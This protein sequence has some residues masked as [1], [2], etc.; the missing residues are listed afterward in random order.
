MSGKRRTP[1]TQ[2]GQAPPLGDER[3]D[4]VPTEVEDTPLPADE[5]VTEV[6]EQPPI[7]E[8]PQDLQATIHDGQGRGHTGDTLPPDALET[9]QGDEAG[10]PTAA[11]VPYDATATVQDAP[12]FADDQIQVLTTPASEDPELAADGGE[13]RI[14]PGPA[15][16]AGATDTLGDY[17]QTVDDGDDLEES[18]DLPEDPVDAAVLTSLEKAASTGESPVAAI[19]APTAEPRPGI[20]FQDESTGGPTDTATHSSISTDPFGPQQP[21]SEAPTAEAATVETPT[22][23]D[24]VTVGQ[25]KYQVPEAIQTLNEEGLTRLAEVASAET[26]LMYKELERLTSV[27]ELETLN[28]GLDYYTQLVEFVGVDQT[29]KLS[30]LIHPTF[31]RDRANAGDKWIETNIEQLIEV[32]DK[33]IP[34]KYTRSKWLATIFYDRVEKEHSAY[35]TKNMRRPQ[36]E[37]P[38]VDT[39]AQTVTTPTT[40][41]PSPA[42]EGNTKY[43]K[44]KATKPKRRRR[45]LSLGCGVLGGLLICGGALTLAYASITSWFGGEP[46]QTGEDYERVEFVPADDDTTQTIEIGKVVA[47]GSEVDVRSVYPEEATTEEPTP[48][49]EEPRPSFEDNVSELEHVL[50]SGTN[51]QISDPSNSRR[52]WIMYKDGKLTVTRSGDTNAPK[53]SNLVEAI[54]GESNL[55]NTTDSGETTLHYN[56]LIPDG[57]AV[58][59]AL[60]EGTEIADIV[61]LILNAIPEGAVAEETGDDDDATDESVT[62]LRYGEGDADA[63]ADV[64]RELEEATPAETGIFNGYKPGFDF[65]RRS[66]QEYKDGIGAYARDTFFV[67]KRKAINYLETDESSVFFR[68]GAENTTMSA[69][70]YCTGPD[71]NP[72]KEKIIFS[73]TDTES[74]H[75]FDYHIFQDGRTR[76]IITDQEGNRTDKRDAETTKQHYA[77]IFQYFVN[78]T[79]VLD[80]VPVPDAVIE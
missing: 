76:E 62:T 7:R 47:G 78:T 8:L 2:G 30:K 48:T 3:P 28:S 60:K 55:Y 61:Y 43:R 21:A 27:T 65:A 32:P 80:N 67:E 5:A 40:S 12:I 31:F 1:P 25:I 42:A 44:V 79:E 51:L 49:P 4:E 18:C 38:A 77:A 56:L 10:A 74:G 53:Y 50:M 34:A 26:H 39:E 57:S 9:W 13:G 69:Y 19:G 15:L 24:I 63:A 6:P 59:P 11:D 20:E 37:G 71:G 41:R 29:V 66:T 14:E 58:G 46:S 22:L 33:D 64:L 73:F 17:L 52:S 35:L 75:R 23:T 54:Q 45:W 72:G 70:F 16:P 68:R 36:T